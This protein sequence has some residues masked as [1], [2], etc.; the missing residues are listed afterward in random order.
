[1]RQTVPPLFAVFSLLAAA[2]TGLG[3]AREVVQL[4]HSWDA[5]R[6]AATIIGFQDL[7]KGPHRGGP[8]VRTE[9]T[10]HYEVAGHKYVLTTQDIGPFADPHS[11]ATAIKQ[12]FADQKPVSCLFYRE[13]PQVSYL[14]QPFSLTRF[15]LA[16]IFPV[17]FAVAGSLVAWHVVKEFL[18]GTHQ[19]R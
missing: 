13:L 10:Y 19:T 15:F 1:M 11:G 2:W 7:H 14:K 6:T 18:L 9:F 3:F 5:P 16:L 4:H 8:I 17:C 12:A